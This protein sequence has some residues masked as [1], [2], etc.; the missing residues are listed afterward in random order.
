M[1]AQ[2]QQSYLHSTPS[3]GNN[4]YKLKWIDDNGMVQYSAVKSLFFDGYGYVYPNPI[5]NTEKLQLDKVQPSRIVKMSLYNAL[6]NKINEYAGSQNQLNVSH[7]PQGSYVLEIKYLDGTS[8]KHK[9]I[10]K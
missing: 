9:V 6:G 5:S 10:K 7:L 1:Q 3:Q 8:Y 4:Y 2:A